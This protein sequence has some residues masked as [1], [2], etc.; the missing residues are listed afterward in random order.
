MKKYAPG[1]HQSNF[2]KMGAI[3]I[4]P[5]II[6]CKEKKEIIWKKKQFKKF[7]TYKKNTLVKVFDLY[8]IEIKIIFFSSKCY[9]YL[10]NNYTMITGTLSLRSDKWPG[11]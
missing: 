10:Y 8:Y 2:R 7:N 1:D 9:L 11:F 5:V 3:P 6:L 4:G